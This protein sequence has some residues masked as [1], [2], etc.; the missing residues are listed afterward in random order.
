MR[1]DFAVFICTHGRPNAQHTLNYLLS[2]GY[3]GKWYLVLDDQ[4]DTINQYIDKFGPDNILIFDKNH[5]V[6]SCDTGTNSPQF[7]CI[8][9]AKLA[10]E[11]IAKDMGLSAFVIADDDLKRFRF[12]YD[13]DG[14][15]KSINV[16]NMDKVIEAYT[17]FMLE[18]NI[19][20]T[21]FGFA[22]NYFVGTDCFTNDCV[23]K[24]RIP[25][26][27][28]F[29]NAKFDVPWILCFGEDI[30]TAIQQSKIGQFWMSCV[31]V[32]QEIEPLGKMKGGMYDVYHNIHGIELREYC[33]IY[34]PTTVKIAYYKTDF[35]NT[36]KRENSFPKL[37]SQSLKKI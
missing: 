19:A 11:D 26:N 13:C 24:S 34:N 8:L 6:N 23:Q 5:Y 2:N 35:M 16:T 1:E 15:L 4:D 27:F 37:V 32:Q 21:G 33:Y 10:V 18:A 25:Y 9:Y 20:S 17:D 3:T 30:G 7:K 31:F 36:I 14:S 28:V 12:R 22:Q 29:R